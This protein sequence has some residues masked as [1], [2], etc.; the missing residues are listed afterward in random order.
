MDITSSFAEEEGKTGDAIAKLLVHTIDD[1]QLANKL[2]AIALDNATYNNKAV[3][4]VRQVLN[5]RRQRSPIGLH[6]RCTAH[7]VQL[8]A[9]AILSVPRIANVV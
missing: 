8:I 7:V 5:S 1:Y 2:L 3:G 9:R 4:Q 6:V